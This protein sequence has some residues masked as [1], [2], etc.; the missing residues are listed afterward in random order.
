MY[1]A[2][3]TADQSGALQCITDRRPCCKRDRIGQWYFPSRKLIP[4]LGQGANRAKTF[5]RN[6]GD[7]GTINLNR[8]DDSVHSP[9]GRFCC[10]VSDRNNVNHTLC[11]NVIG[12]LT[13]ACKI[14][15]YCDWPLNDN[16]MCSEYT[17]LEH[18]VSN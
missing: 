17:N 15:E 2:T 14:H 4:I 9:I 7:D 18:K 8:V 6:R 11:V 5:Y 16:N 13:L 12:K 3:R 1:D 10:E